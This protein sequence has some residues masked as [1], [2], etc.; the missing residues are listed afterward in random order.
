MVFSDAG[1]GLC[2]GSHSMRDLICLRAMAM[3]D[4][5][6]LGILEEPM[7]ILFAISVLAFCAMLWASVSMARHLRRSHVLHSRRGSAHD[8]VTQRDS[9]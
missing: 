9:R 4:R 8:L 3:H 2:V 1:G 7:S 5:V 6:A